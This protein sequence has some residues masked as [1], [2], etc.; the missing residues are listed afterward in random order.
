MNEGQNTETNPIT[1]E[2]FAAVELKVGLIETV[3]SVPKSKKLLK[4]QVNMGENLGRRQIL[5]G[6]SPYYTPESLVGKSVIVVANLEPAMLMGL[7]SQGMLLAV[8]NA[9][10]SKVEV[11]E[12]PAGFSPGDKIR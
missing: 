2:Q 8:Q 10:Q 1:I 4:L 11:I 5:S 12:A 6:I 3:E 7:E 9:D